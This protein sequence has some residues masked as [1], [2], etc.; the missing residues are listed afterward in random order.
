MKKSF[1]PIIAVGLLALYQQSFAA[2]EDFTVS[3]DA[4]QAGTDG[5]GGTGS[6]SGTL[7]FDTVANTLTL[8][9][10][11]YSG[12]SA[13]S[14]LAH[15][16]GSNTSVPGQSAG[17]LYDLAGFTTLGGTAG[18]FNG[19]VSLV[20]GTGGF[21][22]AQQIAQLEGGLWYINIHSSSFGSGEI[23]GQILPVPEPSTLALLGLG[24]GALVWRPRRRS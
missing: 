13:N 2:T 21:S 16:H 5:A 18:A 12:L 10:I 11:T 3:L 6:G 20:G 17:V 4:L 15:I 7:S 23:R 24:A 19:T 14:T 22:L 8:N 9:N 1:L